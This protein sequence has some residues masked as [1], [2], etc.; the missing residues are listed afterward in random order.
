MSS[1][2]PLQPSY[3]FRGHSAPIHAVHFLRDNSR[4]I[5]G[6]AEGWTILWDMITRRPAAA[7]RPHAAVILGLGSWGDD[8]IITHGR[9]S[10][11]HVWLVREQDEHTLSQAYSVQE[12][13]NHPKPRLLHSLDVHTLNF[14]SFASVP[15]R[16]SDNLLIAVPSV[17]DGAIILWSLPFETLL[18][19]VPPVPE[20]KTGMIMALSLLYHQ[21]R[22]TII[23]GHEAGWVA[24]YSEQEDRTWRRI[25]RCD[26]A[27][28]PDPKQPVLSVDVWLSNPSI[29]FYSGA[30]QAINA[31]S[32]DQRAATRFPTGHSGQ[33]SLRIRSDGTIFATAGWDGRGRVYSA[34]NMNDIK[35]L[36]VLKYHTEG[37]YALDFA[38]ILPSETEETASDATSTTN[39]TRRPTAAQQRA[40]KVQRTH[41]IALGS[42]DGRISLWDVF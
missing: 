30:D 39:V 29:I 22:L 32:L 40:R 14:C 3:V 10:K 21:D 37:C 23:A 25:R 12:K 9:D 17:S 26:A 41:W 31:E 13:A 24:V 19:T 11:L 2:A 27:G 36:A 33:Q 20:D 16:G 6:D 4:L 38:K 34:S 8:K 18:G 15:A 28:M 35:E 7:W 1:T 42:K 5:T